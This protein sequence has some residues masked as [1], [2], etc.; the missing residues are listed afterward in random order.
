MDT[1][2]LALVEG[3]GDELLELTGVTAGDELLEADVDTELLALVEG[4]G[5]G[6][7]E[8]LIELFREILDNPLEL[9]MGE[10]EI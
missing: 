4:Y 3:A 6:L 7:A 8:I 10:Y 9:L 1:E 5:A 2:L